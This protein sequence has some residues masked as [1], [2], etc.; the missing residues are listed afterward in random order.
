[1][2]SGFLCPV[3]FQDF[4]HAREKN[5]V[6]RLALEAFVTRDMQVDFA[7]LFAHGA[8]P[9]TGRERNPAFSSPIGDTIRAAIVRLCAWKIQSVSHLLAISQ[10][11]TG[12]CEIQVGPLR[13]KTGQ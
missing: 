6:G 13:L 7:A 9:L 4:C 1:V 2:Q 5:P 8:L 11:K 10:S 12:H 3:V